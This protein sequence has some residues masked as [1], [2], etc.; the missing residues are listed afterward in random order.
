MTVRR[1]A[2]LRAPLTGDHF[3]GLLASLA[4]AESWSAAAD[5]LLRQL[6]KTAGAQRGVLLIIDAPT[7]R[8][9]VTH[10]LATSDALTTGVGVPLDESEHPLVVA[11]VSLEAAGSSGPGL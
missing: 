2:E 3:D 5:L 4:T 8:L 6:A 1:D 7:H 10:T 9:N 11:A